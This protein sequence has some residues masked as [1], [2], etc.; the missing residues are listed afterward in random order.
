MRSVNDLIE[1]VRA[2]YLEMPALSLTPAQLAR[3]CGIDRTMCDLVLQ[4]RS[5]QKFLGPTPDGRYARL[6]EGELIRPRPARAT[7]TANARSRR[8]S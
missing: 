2:E 3:L 7:L 4:V 5:D 6:V 1:R 8:A